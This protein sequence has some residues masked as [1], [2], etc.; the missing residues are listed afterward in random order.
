MFEKKIDGWNSTISKLTKRLLL[1]SSND[2]YFNR[3]CISC[4][5]ILTK[6]RLLKSSYKKKHIYKLLQKIENFD[7]GTFNDTNLNKYF[8]WLVSSYFLTFLKHVNTSETKKKTQQFL[9][10]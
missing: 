9:N 4:Y 3:Y 8:I 7:I 10:K 1:L 2:L 6:S 5:S